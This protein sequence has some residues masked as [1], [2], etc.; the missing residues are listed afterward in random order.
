[1]NSNL[2]NDYRDT[3]KETRLSPDQRERLEKAVARARLQHEEGRAARPAPRVITR[4]TFAI[5]AA[6]AF[7]GLAGFGALN[8]IG[9]MPGNPAGNAFG[10]KAYALDD[11]AR[12]SGYTEVLTKNVLTCNVGGYFGAW[13]DEN[14]NVVEGT[15]GYSFRFDLECIGENV[16]SYSYRI[17]GDQTYFGLT[18]TDSGVFE[19]FFPHG[20]FVAKKYTCSDSLIVT[21]ENQQKLG[22]EKSHVPLIVM[23][24]PMDEEFQAAYDYARSIEHTG[25]AKEDVIESGSA[26]D[27]F[28]EFNAAQRIA[29]C[30]LHVTATYEDGSSETKTYV[31][32]PVEDYEERYLSFQEQRDECLLKELDGEE[33]A[34]AYP[35][36]PE[37]YTITEIA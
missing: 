17:E 16:A 35:E 18:G 20:S 11:P 32:A 15:L 21:K 23:A 33:S 8:V 24:L 25:A 2:T 29:A 22:P 19:E 12:P 5:G 28:V 37:L 14:G 9:G 4:R 3:M 34:D 30:S 7:V 26:F 36:E 10:L 27:R 31:I 13:E 6:A 1:M